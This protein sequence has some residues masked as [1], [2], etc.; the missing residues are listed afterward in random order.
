MALKEDYA[1]RIKRTEEIKNL[2]QMVD[3]LITY[4][5][6]VDANLAQLKMY[7]V[8]RLFLQKLL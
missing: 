6:E 3:L 8:I 1:V 5:K 4:K 7:E 2:Q